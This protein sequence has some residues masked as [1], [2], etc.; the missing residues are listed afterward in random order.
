MQLWRH[1]S[2]DNIPYVFTLL[3]TRQPTLF[4]KSWGKYCSSPQSCGARLMSPLAP[5]RSLQLQRPTIKKRHML[6]W[7]IIWD[8]W[9]N[10]NDNAHIRSVFNIAEAPTLL[11]KKFSETYTYPLDKSR[12]TNND[13]TVSSTDGNAFGHFSLWWTLRTHLF[14]G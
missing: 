8:L 7:N 1:F 13:S 9:L 3:F 6:I 11:H 2:A 14:D 4:D 5:I 12:T 10:K